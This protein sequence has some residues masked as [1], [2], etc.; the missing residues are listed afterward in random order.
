MIKALNFL[1]ILAMLL[2]NFVFRESSWINPLEKSKEFN[3]LSRL[4]S[5]SF[6]L[7]I[8]KW[9]RIEPRKKKLILFFVLKF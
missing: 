3:Q 8:L 7:S 6:I 1:E 4:K 5:V 9:I 2:V